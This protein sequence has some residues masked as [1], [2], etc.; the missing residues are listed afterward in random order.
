M[1]PITHV[2]NVS[3]DV[4]WFVA[5]SMESILCFK[6]IEMVILSVYYIIPF[7]FI[8]FGIVKA[9]RFNYFTI[10]CLVREIWLGLNTCSAHMI[11]LVKST[12]L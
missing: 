5:C 12:Q 6:T 7:D 10:L 1:S 4:S 8:L 2:A 11:H 3:G 9:S